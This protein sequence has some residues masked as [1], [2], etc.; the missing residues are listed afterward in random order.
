MQEAREGLG[1][2]PAVRLPPRRELVARGLHHQIARERV[3]V[4]AAAARRE[5]RPR[6]EAALA[7]LARRDRHAGD[8]LRVAREVDEVGARRRGG[9]AVVVGVGLELRGARARVYDEARHEVATS[10]HRS[11]VHQLCL[12]CSPEAQPEHAAAA[13]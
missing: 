2:D 10:T 3:A 8:V 12:L 11:H 1:Q 4:R 9:R 7:L 5:P 13:C 6:R